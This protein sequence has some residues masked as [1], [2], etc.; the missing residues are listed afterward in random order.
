MRESISSRNR[1]N[2]GSQSLPGSGN[3]SVKI[4]RSGNGFGPHNQPFRQVLV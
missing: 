4:E 3:M 1:L 2:F